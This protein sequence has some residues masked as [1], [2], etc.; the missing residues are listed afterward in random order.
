M[1]QTPAMPAHWARVSEELAELQGRLV[2]LQRFIP[3][4]AFAKLSK[5]HR[6]MLTL[7]RDAMLVLEGILNSRLELAESEGF[8]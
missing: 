2:G 1:S 3:T 7:Q 4:P 6:D 8:Q 5:R